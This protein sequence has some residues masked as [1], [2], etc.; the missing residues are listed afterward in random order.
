MY[1]QLFG[2]FLLNHALLTAN[3]L[4][5]AMETAKNTRVKLGV[6]A[7]NAGY[8]T[9]AQVDHCYEMQARMDKRMGDIAVELGYMTEAQVEELLRTQ[10]S[11]YLILGQAIMDRGFLTN[12]Q[13]E[14]ALSDYKNSATITEQDF[15]A[16]TE[17][18]AEEVLNRYYQIS[19]E[20]AFDGVTEYISLLMKNLVRFI[21]DDFSL[22]KAEKAEYVPAEIMA[23]QPISGTVNLATA[24]C[25][26]EKSF[27]VFAS[28]Y[29]NEEFTELDEY[30]EASVGEFL[31]LHN[32]LFTVNMSEQKNVELE[33]QPQLV[34]RCGFDG[35]GGGYIIPVQFSFGVV[36]FVIASK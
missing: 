20:D 35:A 21:G 28:R 6:L 23:C 13:F 18:K 33:L 30:V 3:Q 22:L 8:L 10:K 7:I 11:G 5:E 29:A 12:A 16:E 31:N 26:D 15:L 32:G 25:S 24:V 19:P 17:E 14:Q 9:A 1:T 2:G 34:E 36:K 4:A 27:V